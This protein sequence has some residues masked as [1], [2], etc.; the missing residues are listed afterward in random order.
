MRRSLFDEDDEPVIR[1]RRRIVED[2]AGPPPF[3]DM[4]YEV[5]ALLRNAHGRGYDCRMVGCSKFANGAT[6][7]QAVAAAWRLREGQ[8]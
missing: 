4:L 6:P 5:Q 1:P 2:A 7:E 3:E 8:R